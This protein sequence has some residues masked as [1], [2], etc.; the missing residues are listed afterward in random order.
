MKTSVVL[1]SSE[2]RRK[3]EDSTRTIWQLAMCM[4]AL[5]LV[6]E[7]TTADM[8]FPWR[9]RPVILESLDAR[10]T[11]DD[12]IAD[13]F[14][15]SLIY[16]VQSGNSPMQ[17]LYCLRLER[18]LGRIRRGRQ[19]WHT[20][21][22]LAHNG[23]GLK[24]LDMYNADTIFYTLEQGGEDENGLLGRLTCLNS[25]PTH[26]L[27]ADL[28][29]VRTGKV[30][31]YDPEGIAIDRRNNL[32]YVMTDD[33]P[34]TDVSQYS[35]HPRTLDLT[36]RWTTSV[37]APGSGNGNNGIVLSDGRVAV[38]DGSERVAIYAVSPDGKKV[39]NLLGGWIVNSGDVPQD[40][41]E[42]L[43]NLYLF[44]EKGRIDAFDAFDLK[45]M[46]NKPAASWELDSMVG[47]NV[48]IGGAAMTADGHLI[49]CTRNKGRSADAMQDKIFVFDAHVPTP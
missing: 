31:A 29:G 47:G 43:G 34:N 35:I 9:K 32:L 26:A 25:T 28:T 45:S 44:W 20:I 48:S 16:A 42:H 17:K 22:T 2:S 14:D 33:G 49:V 21:S 1:R 41:V 38:V 37:A 3:P 39:V 19:K 46:S 10:L 13:P 24:S 40:L 8:P 23:K 30:D 36:H 27:A 11:A 12:V 7:S 4:A 6:A 5:L 18:T 15:E